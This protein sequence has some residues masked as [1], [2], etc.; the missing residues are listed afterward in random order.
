MLEMSAF[1]AYTKI[2]DVDKL[3]WRIKNEWTVWIRC[4]LNVGTGSRSEVL[5]EKFL[6][7]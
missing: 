1:S 7:T 4:S 6:I 5:C 3:R 2:S